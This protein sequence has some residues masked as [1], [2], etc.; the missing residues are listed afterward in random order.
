MIWGVLMIAA[1]WD[2]HDL[3]SDYSRQIE[4]M[5][6]YKYILYPHVNEVGTSIIVSVSVDTRTC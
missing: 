6:K 4:N 2:N 5:N 1:R 3:T